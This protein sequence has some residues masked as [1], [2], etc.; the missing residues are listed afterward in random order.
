MGEGEGAA[1]GVGATIGV[2]IIA[3]GSGIGSS[4]RF[5]S[6]PEGVLSTFLSDFSFFSSGTGSTFFST[7]DFFCLGFVSERLLGDFAFSS[8]AGRESKDVARCVLG[9]ARPGE[10]PGS[11]EEED[12]SIIGIAENARVRDEVGDV[13]ENGGDVASCSA[14]AAFAPRFTARGSLMR[15]PRAAAACGPPEWLMPI[16]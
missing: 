3:V 12:V 9:S 2:I 7:T 14:R 16:K 6:F 15:F 5:F 8:F 1:A 4:C 11:E 10:E 13:G